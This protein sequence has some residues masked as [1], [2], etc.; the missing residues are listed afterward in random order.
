MQTVEPYSIRCLRAVEDLVGGRERLCQELN[1]SSG[2]VS[3]WIKERQI[4]RGA[5]L[6]LVRLSGGKFTAEEF[7]GKNDAN[8]N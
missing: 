2:A 7:L 6:D 4:A 8:T 1:L 5:I 3:R